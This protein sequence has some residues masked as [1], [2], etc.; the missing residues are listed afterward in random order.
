M[1][2]VVVVCMY[3]ESWTADANVEPA[4]TR[5]WRAEFDTKDAMNA[6]LDQAE[7]HAAAFEEL[8]ARPLK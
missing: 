2:E 4:H 6:W 1:Y 7:E 5:V 8:G 3:P